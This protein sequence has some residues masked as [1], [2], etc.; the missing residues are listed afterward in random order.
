MK[1][2]K[3]IPQNK[4]KQVKEIAELMK[5]K[6]IIVCSIKNLKAAQLQQIRKRIR[7]KVFLKIAKKNLI[8]L[9]I[10]ET[11]NE[12]LKKVLE[13]INADYCLLFSN[14]DAF[15]IIS[16][17]ADNKSP[18]KARAGQEATEDIWVRAGPTSLAPGPDISLLSSVGLQP[19]VE[20]GKI[21]I[22]KDSLFIKK[23][24]KISQEKAAILSKLDIIPF[25]SGLEPLVAFYEE[26]LYTS[27]KIDKK[28]TLH[29]LINSYSKGLAF[30]VSITWISKETLP[31]VLMKAAS[32]ENVLKNL[33]QTPTKSGETQ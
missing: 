7:D 15:N 30:A 1:R 33:I 9:A 12:N 21:A 26:K 29:D 18:A 19:K 16:I 31:F 5:M 6:S 25:E 17:L 32:H 4:K 11:K 20:G 13:H 14:E 27:V 24:E 23:G 28:A 3:P 8:K 10:E 22:A 2:N